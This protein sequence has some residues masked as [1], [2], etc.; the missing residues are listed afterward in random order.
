MATQQ[1]DLSQ[2]RHTMVNA[3]LH[4]YTEVHKDGT[5]TL[6]HIRAHAHNYEVPADGSEIIID[7][8]PDDSVESRHIKDGTILKEDMSEQLQGELLMQSQKGT[9]GGVASLGQDGKVPDSQLP[10]MAVAQE[11]DVRAIVSG[12]NQQ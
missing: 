5:E 11:A 8:L 6:R 4:F 12:Y 10:E 9:S 1:K 7:T 3:P 2:Y